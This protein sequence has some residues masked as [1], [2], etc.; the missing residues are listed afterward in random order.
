M[1]MELARLQKRCL[2]GPKIEHRPQENRPDAGMA[3]GIDAGLA[4]AETMPASCS[5]ANMG[6]AQL[7]LGPVL[8]SGLRDVQPRQ[9][10]R[11]RRLQPAP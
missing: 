3:A 5:L 8:P 7:R 11:S 4:E 9:R 6:P 2:H 10:F 1:A